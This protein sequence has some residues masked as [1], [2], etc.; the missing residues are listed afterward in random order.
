MSREE[1]KLDLERV[2]FIGR[3]Y[4]EYMLMFNLSQEELRNKKILDC[5]AG[6]CSFTAIAN[7]KGADVTAT[8]IVYYHPFEQL[9]EKG[10][11]DIE[12]VILNMEKAQSNYVWDYFNDIEAYELND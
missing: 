9:A 4:E 10:F 5:P 7:K 1:V 3:T 6:A 2:V 8:D 11:D 12:H